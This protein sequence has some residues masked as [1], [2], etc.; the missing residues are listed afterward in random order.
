MRTISFY[1]LFLVFSIP[2]TIKF[3]RKK[4]IKIT[5]NGICFWF[6]RL[7]APAGCLQYHYATSGVIRSFN[8]SPSPNSLPNSIGVDGSRQIASLNYGICIRAV[9][10]CS[11]TYSIL[12]S[13]VY[14]FTMT[15]DVGAVDP[16][17]LGTGTLQEQFCKS[18]FL[19]ELKRN[20]K[21]FKIK[22]FL[23]FYGN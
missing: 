20:T 9:S 15:G 19:I 23:R 3:I 7:I 22:T 17:L 12:S 11:I 10:S 6:Y 16:V 13:D 8:Y 1:I 4:F 14:S 21:I 2:K 5:L 18:R